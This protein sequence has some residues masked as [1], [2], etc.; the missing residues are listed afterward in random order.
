M[1]FFNSLKQTWGALSAPQRVAT[2]L[3]L[4]AAVGLLAG[5][6]W[7]A[8]KVEYRPLAVGDPTKIGQIATV[9]ESSGIVAKV[10]GNAVQVPVERFDEAMLAIA[11]N[12]LNTDG[13]GFEILDK[14]TNAFTTS[15]MEKV[16]VQRAVAGELER[17]I[18]G[19][20][21][22]SSARVLISQDRETWRASEKD[23]TASVSV[24]LRPGYS[25]NQGDVSAIQSC[26][27]NAWHSLKPENVAVMANGRKLT[28]DQSGAMDTQ[29][30]AANYQ[31]QSQVEFEETIR[32]RAQEA[33]DR[34]QGAG[35]TYVTVN[36]ELNFDTKMEKIHLIDKENTAA[37]SEDIKE[38]T[39]NNGLADAGG[40]TGV[41]SNTPG[42]TKNN[43][44]G[45]GAGRDVEKT[46]TT[47]FENSFTD[48]MS[49][50]R[51][52]EVKRISVALFVDQALK[53]RLP[54]LERTVKAAVGFD[55]R[56]EDQFSATAESEFAK[57]A[58]A[59]PEAAPVSSN[60]MPELVSTG[61]RV[62]A[63]IGLVVMF[64]LLLKRAGNGPRFTPQ[65]Q[66]AGGASAARPASAGGGGGVAD[67][68]AGGGA[69]SYG[70]DVAVG[71]PGSPEDMARQAVARSAAVAATSDPASG[72]RVVRSW[73]EEK[74]P[75]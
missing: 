28:R 64:L 35:R 58:D 26:V 60:S 66:V 6:S 12:G 72:G 47:K 41:T 39:H 23:G 40:P 27:A 18:R 54:E 4:L 42:D 36:A 1:E 3:V 45:G 43:A 16:N 74:R 22:I 68:P 29:F 33:L 17:I 61:G 25:L 30:T 34:A 53:A 2:I 13:V 65:G 20:P 31:L 32:K 75:R 71:S 38:S 50:K 55:E 24:T 44:S 14:S 19:Y 7:F 69:V 9:L 63:L 10:S 56:R 46:T 15:L 57:A 52:F 11:R 67:S 37:S 70:G 51:G 8:N 21:G 49:E 48:R 73:L 59:S 5:I 62:L